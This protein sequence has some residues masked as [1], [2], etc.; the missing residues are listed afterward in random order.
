MIIYVLNNDTSTSIFFK[1]LSWKDSNEHIIRGL[2]LWD[3]VLNFL[4]KVLEI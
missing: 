2:L 3:V 4:W 1:A